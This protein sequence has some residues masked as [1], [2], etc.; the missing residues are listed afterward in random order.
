MVK[1][2]SNRLHYSL[3]VVVTL[4]LVSFGVYAVVPTGSAPN[5]GHSIQDVGAPSS[6]ISGQ[7][8]RYTESAECIYEGEGSGPCWL[9][10]TVSTPSLSGFISDVEYVENSGYCS[11]G[12]TATCP[13]GK[14]VLGGGCSLTYATGATD[15]LRRSSPTSEGNSWYCQSSYDGATSCTV[16]AICADID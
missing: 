13:S 6:C 12:L 1:K 5:P 15:F 11:G 14:Y 3:V 16:Y 2:I 10:E 7:Y 9:C 4:I 8:L